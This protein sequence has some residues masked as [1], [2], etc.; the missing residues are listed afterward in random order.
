[1]VVKIG[2]LTLGYLEITQPYPKRKYDF[3][4]QKNIPIEKESQAADGTP[5][6]IIFGSY[7]ELKDFE[8]IDLTEADITLLK[9]FRGKEIQLIIDP[10]ESYEISYNIYLKGILEPKRHRYMS[11]SWRYNIDL[12]NNL[13]VR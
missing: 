7:T 8:L 12:S 5:K 13:V 6:Y 11:N 10:G 9:S 3:L 1:M 4:S 2:N